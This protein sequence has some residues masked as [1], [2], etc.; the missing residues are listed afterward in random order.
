MDFGLGWFIQKY[1][2]NCFRKGVFQEQ[3]S[4]ISVVS[5]LGGLIRLLSCQDGLS[6]GSFLIWVVLLGCCHIRVVSHV[7]VL[8]SVWSFNKVCWHQF[9]LST[10]CSHISL[11]SHQYGLLSVWS[12]IRAVSSGWS[13]VWVVFHQNCLSSGWSLVRVVSHQFGLSSGWSL[14]SLVFHK[15]G[16]SSVWSFIRMVSYQFGRS[17]GWSLI[18]LVFHQDGLSSAVPHSWKTWGQLQHFL[19]EPSDFMYYMHPVFVLLLPVCSIQLQTLCLSLSVMC[20]QFWSS[21]TGSYW[22]ALP[23]FRDGFTLRHATSFQL[24]TPCPPPPPPKNKLQIMTTVSEL[25]PSFWVSVSL[26]TRGITD[27]QGNCSEHFLMRIHCKSV[28]NGKLAEPVSGFTMDRW[29]PTR[30][31]CPALRGCAPL[32]WIAWRSSRSV[33]SLT[34]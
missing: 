13:L 27:N 33:S 28:L 25:H 19:N 31:C 15:D 26:W 9:G 24:K 2:Q 16:L 1:V 14:I 7:G 21:I 11:V 5:H 20:T 29:H 6:S 17:S 22:R 30:C 3:W 12:F 34:I 18:S 10:G 32:P 8:T 4:H 23:F